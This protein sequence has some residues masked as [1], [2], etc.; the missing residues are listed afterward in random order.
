MKLMQVLDGNWRYLMYTNH[1]NETDQTL[2]PDT[3]TYALSHCHTQV[4]ETAL[5]CAGLRLSAAI[6]AEGN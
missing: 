3:N 4:T 2:R 6:L 5:I 1:A